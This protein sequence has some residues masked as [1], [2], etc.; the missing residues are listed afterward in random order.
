MALDR[1]NYRA[2]VETTVEIAG[3][4][5]LQSLSCMLCAG[6]AG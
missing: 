4:V 5:G 2:L 3:K 1:R 6:W